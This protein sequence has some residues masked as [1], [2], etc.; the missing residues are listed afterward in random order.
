[1][2]DGVVRYE[3]AGPVARITFDRPEARNAMTWSMYDQLADCCDRIEADRSVRVAVL[4]GAGGKAFVA[5]TDIS[6][7]RAFD[8]A[9]DG[10]AY[11]QRMDSILGRL[12]AV[13]VPTIAVID[14]WA[15][16]G[17]LTIAACCDWR[18]ATPA[19]RFGVPIART[20]GN[21]LSMRSYARLV[22]LVGPTRTVQ[23]LLGAGFFSAEQ[24]SDAGLVTE[25][26]EPEALDARVEELCARL[27]G[28]APL[29][30][31]A[32]KRAVRRITLDNIPDGEDLVRMCY[33]SRD[34]REG[35]R[36]FV[37]K[38]DPTWEGE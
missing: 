11:E 27:A 35:V 5:G 36:A 29:T 4:R 9:D 12:E 33:G 3:S 31:E 6:Q 13:R 30:M 24:A 32:T 16:G 2:S 18:M 22:A 8:G 1:M 28:N 15:V 38:R 34:F 37:D 21:C 7:F 25:I 20:I 10:V 26:V 14:G 17:G 23:L 19:A